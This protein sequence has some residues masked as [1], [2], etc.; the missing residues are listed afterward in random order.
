MKFRLHALLLQWHNIY[1]ATVLTTNFIPSLTSYSVQVA[2]IKQHHLV[3]ILKPWITL[4]IYWW[5][6]SST[7]ALEQWY[8]KG[9]IL[10]HVSQPYEFCLLYLTFI[11]WKSF[12]IYEMF[13]VYKL[14][15][16]YCCCRIHGFVPVSASNCLAAKL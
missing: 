16:H 1:Q 14:N 2:Y 11:T 6:I 15:V 7:D 4:S 13:R 5:K 3:L 10:C 12:K 8:I 9:N